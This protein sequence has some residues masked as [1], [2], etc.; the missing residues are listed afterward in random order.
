[1]RGALH[2]EA[3]RLILRVGYRFSLPAL[4]GKRLIGLS[5]AV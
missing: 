3:S 2:H 1:M 4:F 5:E